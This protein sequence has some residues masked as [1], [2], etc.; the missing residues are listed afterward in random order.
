MRPRSPLAWSMYAGPSSCSSPMSEL[1]MSRHMACVN[2]A[3]FCRSSASSSSLVMMSPRSRAREPAFG[4]GKRRSKALVEAN[5]GAAFDD[6]GRK[7]REDARVYALV[8][9]GVA[10]R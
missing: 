9:G 8:A 7:R 10:G 1:R 6:N 5:L 4:G 3:A 2:T